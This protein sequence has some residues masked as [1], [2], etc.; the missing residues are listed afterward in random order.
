V[1]DALLYCILAGTSMRAAPSTSSFHESSLLSSSSQRRS[2]V[3]LL[4]DLSLVARDN[5]ATV[6]H[7]LTTV[8]DRCFVTM[9]D[10]CRSR[11]LWLTD[12]LI[13]ADAAGVEDVVTSLVRHAPGGGRHDSGIGG[14]GSGNGNGNGGGSGGGNGE[15][16]S[17][18]LTLPYHVLRLLLTHGDW[19]CVD[20]QRRRRLRAVATYSF[21]RLLADHATVLTTTKTTTTTTSATMDTVLFVNGNVVN[22]DDDTM[23]DVAVRV[24]PFATAVTTTA[25]AAAAATIAGA[26]AAG[27]AAAAAAAAGAAA[28]AAVVDVHCLVAAETRYIVAQLLPPRVPTAST[29]NQFSNRSRGVRVDDGVDADVYVQRALFNALSGVGRDAVRVLLDLTHVRALTPAISALNRPFDAAAAAAAAAAVAA[30]VAA[31]GVAVSDSDASS[32]LS[33]A[34]LVSS[35]SSLA[36]VLPLAD[37]LLSIPTLPACLRS[38]VTPDAERH[39]VWMLTHVRSKLCV[40]EFCFFILHLFF[41]SRHT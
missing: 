16:C 23:Q 41:V 19:M 24:F 27:A 30:A 37:H 15:H 39:L 32:S 21:M 31:G 14:N 17:F 22:D 34:S 18:A 36:A 3:R 4:R 13:R 29:N 8:I 35:M 40:Y 38:R 10:E 11:C 9:T 25:A 26:T 2:C 5:Y 6:T 12:A 1:C 33:S 20:D 28:G 7:Q